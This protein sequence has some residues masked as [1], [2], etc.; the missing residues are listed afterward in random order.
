MDRRAF[1]ET[2]S[3]P[4][5]SLLPLGRSWAHASANRKVVI[6]IDTTGPNPADGHRLV[7]VAA[8]EIIGRQISGASFRSY[9][10][11]KWDFATDGP[12]TNGLTQA[13]LDDNPPFSS[14]ARELAGFMGN[15]TLI[16]HDAQFHLEFL[17]REF[18]V[19]G[20]EFSPARAPIDVY[21]L[22]GGKDF[23]REF[24]NYLWAPVGIGPD[25]DTLAFKHAVWFARLYLGITA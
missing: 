17:K 12:L 18:S 16:F 15:D 22:A 11:P 13:D 2:L 3:L 25:D 20:H 21:E 19:A 6:G 8:V 9:L 4:A 10:N 14:I 23:S 7:E 1:L 5:I 24:L